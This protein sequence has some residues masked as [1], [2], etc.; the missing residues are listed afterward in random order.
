MKHKRIRL[1]AFIM[2]GIIIIGSISFLMYNNFTTHKE[3]EEFISSCS[4]HVF[5]DVNS[6]AKGY[7]SAKEGNVY[8][9]FSEQDA[10]LIST[11]VTKAVKENYASNAVKSADI[12]TL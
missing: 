10:L 8:A 2:T 12:K 4:D 5:S 11:T 1:T 3:K 7:Y 9:P 6:F